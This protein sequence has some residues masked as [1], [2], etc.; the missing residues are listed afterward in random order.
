MKKILLITLLFITAKT[1]AQTLKPIDSF[2]GIKFGSSYATVSAAVKAKGGILDAP[3]STPTLMVFNNVS[4]GSRK[5][6]YFFV[7]LIDDKAY[8]AYFIFKPELEPQ[9]L[10]YYNSL[11]TD[12]SEFYGK[13]V[14]VKNFKQPY[15]EGDGFEVQAIKTGNA[16]YVN[17]WTYEKNRIYATTKNDGTIALM[18]TDGNLSEIAEAKKKEKEK[19]EF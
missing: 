12:V 1:N 13:S 2:L 6:D 19:A 8:T 5:S 3:A 15:E 4:L 10:D 14:P 17:F 7:R 16:E 11:I 9:L 18:Y